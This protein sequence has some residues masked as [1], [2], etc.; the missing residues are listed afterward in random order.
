[1][2]FASDPYKYFAE[3]LLLMT[4]QPCKIRSKLEWTC[5]AI[6]KRLIYRRF[7]R[8]ILLR[9]KSYIKSIEVFFYCARYF[10]IKTYMNGSECRMRRDKCS[11]VNNY[12]WIFLGRSRYFK[13]QWSL[14]CVSQVLLYGG[15]SL[16]P[17]NSTNDEQAVYHCATKPLDFIMM[18]F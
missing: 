13:F 8:F 4:D 7:Q 3:N 11:N 10:K 18:P 16:K 1:M 14:V 2:A 17:C 15:K 5:C 9:Y 6:N 12:S